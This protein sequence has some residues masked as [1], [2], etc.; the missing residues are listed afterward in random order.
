MQENE[1]I[2]RKTIS[3]WSATLH[4]YQLIF[5]IKYQFFLP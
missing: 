4:Q 5:L 2:I 1:Y 3:I